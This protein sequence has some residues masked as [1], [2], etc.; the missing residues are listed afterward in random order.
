M[1]NPIPYQYCTLLMYTRLFS[2][3][4]AKNAFGSIV[5][6]IKPILDF[7]DRV[8]T[9]HSSCSGVLRCPAALRQEAGHGLVAAESC[10]FAGPMCSD[11][12]ALIV[13]S[14]VHLAVPEPEHEHELGRH[15]LASLASDHLFL[16]CPGLV[17][18]AEDAAGLVVAVVDGASATH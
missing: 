13:R 15:R 14:F 3:G 9:S 17:D 11:I 12:A 2:G 10:F 5:K 8:V 1:I 18:L 7:I 4:I 16:A 6:S